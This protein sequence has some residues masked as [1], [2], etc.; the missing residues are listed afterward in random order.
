MDMTTPPVFNSTPQLSLIPSCSSCFLQSSLPLGPMPSMMVMLLLAMDMTTPSE[1]PMVEML[2]P[3][4]D[5]TTQLE[6][7]MMDMLLPAMDMTTPSE[8]HMVDILL[9]AMDKATQY[10]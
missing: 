1:L 2:L 10:E 4:M 7:P 5:M 8:L 6:L 3:A 9:P